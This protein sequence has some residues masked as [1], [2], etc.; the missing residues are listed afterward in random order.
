LTIEAESL[1]EAGEVTGVK[2]VGEAG[3]RKPDA[4]YPYSPLL[5]PGGTAEQAG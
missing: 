1:E 3:L 2:E 4:Q 5:P